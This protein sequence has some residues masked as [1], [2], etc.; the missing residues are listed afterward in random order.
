MSR[1]LDDLLDVSRIS[2]NRMELRREFATLRSV[3]DV[4]LETSR[5]L[6]E[7]GGHSLQLDVPDDP[8]HLDADPVRLSQVFSNLLNNAAKFSRAG[9]PIHL[10]V[11]Q[12]G[13][14]EVR[15][16]VT[17]HGVGID[18]QTL[19]RVFDLFVQAPTI[20]KGGLGIG[21]A[22]T[23]S[24]VEMHG[25]RIAARSEG[26]NRGAELIVHLPTVDPP[27][28]AASLPKRRSSQHSNHGVY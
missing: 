14:D 22:L 26:A 28:L 9:D 1:L 8:I 12:T 11:E 13:H 2:R 21:L 19:P 23:K 16:T 4:A 18:P 10:K 7:A 3:L 17:D 6:I 27:T 25:G 24:V 20:E 5:P 15:V